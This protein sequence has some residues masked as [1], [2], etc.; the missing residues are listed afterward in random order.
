MGVDDVKRRV[1]G[2]MERFKESWRLAAG[3][4]AAGVERSAGTTSEPDPRLSP[5]R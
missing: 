2:D 4:P 3:R 1:E 5:Y